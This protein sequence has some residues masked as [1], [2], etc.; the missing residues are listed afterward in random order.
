M[1]SSLPSL[2]SLLGLAALSLLLLAGFIGRSRFSVPGYLR[3]LWYFFLVFSA[4]EWIS[5]AVAIWILALY[6]FPALR[7]YFSLVDIRLQDRWAI[8]VAY[9]CIPFVF[10]L[11]QIDWY[12]FFIV[13]IPVYAFLVIPFFVVLGGREAKGTL[14]S[15]SVIDFGL[16]LLVYCMGHIGYLLRFST[17]LALLLVL[18]VALCD[19]V[20]RLPRI[21]GRWLWRIVLLKYMLS[22][23]L[24]LA[25]CFWV[26]RLTQLPAPH[27]LALG[28]LLPL[29]VLMG[30]F[31][32]RALEV[33]LGISPER[34]E[35]GRGRIFDAVKSYV[36]TAPVIFHYLRYFTDIL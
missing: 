28:L 21:A 35:P 22:A 1:W 18:G 36:F 4:A 24:C 17:W 32:L 8:L 6:A 10:Y 14:L 15:I 26:G 29:L 2:F 5:F 34:L 11:I 25:L 19:L 20:D 27:R 33:D 13:S 16:F 3:T 9:L 31:T 7:E 12:G 23:P 30:N